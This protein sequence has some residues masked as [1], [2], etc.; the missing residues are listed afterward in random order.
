MIPETD[1][2]ELIAHLCMVHGFVGK[3]CKIF[4]QKLRC[5]NYVTPKNYLDFLE[6]KDQ[7]ILCNK[8]GI[9]LPNYHYGVL[10][11]YK[12]VQFA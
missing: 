4:L 7:Y 1:S 2:V 3:F 8:N 10:F 6:D 5:S 11:V 12:H 9:I